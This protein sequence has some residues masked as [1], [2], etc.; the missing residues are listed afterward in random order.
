MFL[1]SLCDSDG[2]DGGHGRGLGGLDLL[3]LLDIVAGAAITT[4]LHSFLLSHRSRIWG[5]ARGHFSS[6]ELVPDGW[7][8]AVSYHR[9]F[10]KNLSQP[11][12]TGHHSPVSLGNDA[13]D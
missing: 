7:R 1:K 11:R 4:L 3:T 5:G 13:R 12:V 9:R 2:V 10:L 6:D 8:P